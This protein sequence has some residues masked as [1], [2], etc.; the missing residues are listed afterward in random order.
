[1]PYIVPRVPS[2]PTGLDYFSQSLGNSIQSTSDLLL[3][4][5]LAGTLRRK[6]TGGVYSG[7]G[8]ATTQISPA[9]MVKGGGGMRLADLIQNRVV[10]STM[11]SQFTPTRHG[12]FE[13]A[14]PIDRQLQQAQLLKAQQDIESAPEERRRTKALADLTEKAASGEIQFGIDPTTGQPIP[15]LP[16]T[17]GN[18]PVQPMQVPLVTVNP[19]TGESSQTGMVP[20]NAKVVSQPAVTTEKAQAFSA[21][22]SM[23]GSIDAMEQALQADPGHLVRSRIPF[24]DRDYR[25]I[26]DQFDKE[27]AIAAGGKQLTTTELNLI[28]STRPTLEDIKSPEAIARKIAKLREIATNAKSRLETGKSVQGV[29]APKLSPKAQSLIDRYR[30]Q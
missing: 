15:M 25:A 26:T 10:P 8:G 24:M 9:E 29:A 6:A 13:M 11:G 1:M 23:M 2:A 14:P 30:G 5:L 3:K 28:R 21:L 22:D 18:I 19:L 7:A 17:R 16:T 12:G 27:A 4:A 20:R